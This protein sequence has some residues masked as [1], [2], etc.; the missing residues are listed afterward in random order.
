M[1][2]KCGS[3]AGSP[4]SGLVAAARQTGGR[5]VCIFPGP[6]ELEVS[7]SEL[8]NYLDCIEFVTGDPG[9]I[10]WLLIATSIVTVQSI[11]RY[12]NRGSRSLLVVGYN[13][14]HRVPLQDE[15]GGHFLP[16]EEGLLVSKLAKNE[17]NG[18]V[19]SGKKSKWVVKMDKSTGENHVFRVTYPQ[20]KVIQN[21]C[22]RAITRTKCQHKKTSA[23]NQN[24]TKTR[25]SKSEKA[26]HH[27][28]HSSTR[29]SQFHFAL[30]HAHVV[31]SPRENLE[32]KHAEGI[33]VTLVSELSHCC[34]LRSQV[35]FLEEHV[36][37][38]CL[39]T[40]VE[41]S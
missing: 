36:N 27:K 19:S 37:N 34:I 9:Q 18:G 7:G 40:M 41:K 33:N 13:G 22:H 38:P 26:N 32:Y 39:V 25:Q 17:V 11:R 30:N 20:H 2:Q 16:I 14:Q 29:G 8:S 28:K 24:Q 6:N 10:L 5:V 12:K 31:T 3:T 23:I 35:Y 15:L 4:T 21:L 1:G